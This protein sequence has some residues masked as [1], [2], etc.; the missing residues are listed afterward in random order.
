VIKT[1]LTADERPAI[2]DQVSQTVNDGYFDPAIGGKDWQASA[3]SI[4]RSSPQFRTISSL[5]ELFN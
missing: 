3:T 5:N 2:F 1:R 4:V